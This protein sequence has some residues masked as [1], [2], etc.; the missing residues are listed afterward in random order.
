[1]LIDHIFSTDNSRAA[2]D[3]AGR[4]QEAQDRRRKARKTWEKA[5]NALKQRQKQHRQTQADAEEGIR[6]L[7]TRLEGI[8]NTLKGFEA[9]RRSAKLEKRKSGMRR[10]DLESL[11]ETKQREEKDLSARIRTET[12]R[13]MELIRF[14]IEDERREKQ[15]KYQ[16]YTALLEQKRNVIQE[17]ATA[18]ATRLQIRFKRLEE[19]IRDAVKGLGYSGVAGCGYVYATLLGATYQFVFFSQ[20]G[21]NIFNYATFVDFLFPGYFLL[22]SCLAAATVLAFYL[23]YLN[24]AGSW[25]L[26]RR[27][28]FYTERLAPIIVHYFVEKP[29]AGL[30]F[31][32][33]LLLLLCLSLMFAA[34]A[35]YYWYHCEKR[36]SKNRISVIFTP[37]SSL[38]REVVRIGSN[39]T[40]MFLKDPN[41]GRS[42]GVQIVPL[43]RIVCISEKNQVSGGCEPTAATFESKTAAF[44][45]KTLSL[46]QKL[47]EQVDAIKK[48]I[49]SPTA[50]S[51]SSAESPLEQ[52]VRRQMTST[53]EEGQEP[54]I[55]KTV[56]FAHSR[57]DLLNEE[58]ER[59]KQSVRELT[60]KAPTQW[61][62]FGFA[63]P[64]G[65][66][67]VN[68]KIS[69]R[70]ARVV[71]A[72]VCTSLASTP[73]STDDEVD[74]QI[75][76]NTEGGEEQL[77]CGDQVIQ[78]RY[79]GEFHSAHGIADSRSAVIGVCINSQPPSQTEAAIVG[80][81]FIG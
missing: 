6:K 24:R 68:C 32:V 36:M 34:A 30:R 3:A 61:A 18:N 69:V 14:N 17:A 12:S 79:A 1:M 60:Q 53:C 73:A 55:V 65:D 64:D 70:R 41:R 48:R 25:I 23:A 81:Q 22:T 56:Q 54:Q 43:S 9:E 72:L 63:S 66:S 26:T 67:K 33:G 16:S 15:R 77:N 40:Y 35:A 42:A 44:W 31:R 8:K 46:Q 21:I 75:C 19:K 11:I 52:F 2:S 39:S 58:I 59:I 47:I 50:S 57:I 71:A 7:E 10:E 27:I 4:L 80:K 13:K 20:G 28:P 29:I 37:P 49:E 45:K 62:V 51:T 78:V 76:S 5:K 38:P 74:T